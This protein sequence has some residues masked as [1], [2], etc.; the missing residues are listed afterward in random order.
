MM[1][2]FDEM[3]TGSQGGTAQLCLFSNTAECLWIEVKALQSV[4]V[5]TKDGIPEPFRSNR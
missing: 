4:R 2:G 3:K 5:K 1:H